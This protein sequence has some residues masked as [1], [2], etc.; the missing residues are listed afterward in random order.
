MLAETEEQVVLDFPES[1]SDY[2]QEVL[3]RWDEEFEITKAKLA[4]GEMK[5]FD[6]LEEAMA[7]YWARKA[8]NGV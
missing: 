7:D 6:S 5:S 3:D 1:D 2:P 8:A 4:T